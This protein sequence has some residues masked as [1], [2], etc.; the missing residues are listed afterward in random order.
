MAFRFMIILVARR[1]K[2]YTKR[3]YYETAINSVLV[4]AILFSTEYVEADMTTYDFPG[5]RANGRCL[6]FL[7]YSVEKE[8]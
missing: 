3:C 8:I 6:V 5:W 4:V 7:Y 2:N 1:S